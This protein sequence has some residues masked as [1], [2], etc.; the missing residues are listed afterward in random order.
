MLATSISGVVS[1]PG[2]LRRRRG[3]PAADRL[4]PVDPHRGQAHGAR[5]HHVVEDAL[6]GVQDV[7]L[8]GAEGALQVAER[9][10]E[11]AQAGLVGAD[12]L[13]GEDAVEDDAELLVAAREGGAVDVGEDH[14]L[15]VALEVLQ[16][17]RAVGEGGPAADR[18]A[19]LGRLAGARLDAP[20]VGQPAMHLGQDLRVEL[21]RRLGLARR[22][23]RAEGFQEGVVVEVA[24]AMA[25]H[26]RAQ[27]GE[28]AAL[29]VDQR[30][31]TVEGQ[32]VE[33]GDVGHGGSPAA[34]SAKT[35]WPRRE[36]GHRIGAGAAV[37]AC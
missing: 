20:L 15:V 16:R 18:L 12:V 31:V 36:I 28:D 34:V 6:G 7:A 32:R 24:A 14:Q 4:A 23:D 30:A 25:V 17:G 9:I 10:L 21:A 13:G 19:E 2:A 3:A 11:I 5:R 37:R 1:A 33:L 27:L 8:L 29:P 35:N 22:L 26:P